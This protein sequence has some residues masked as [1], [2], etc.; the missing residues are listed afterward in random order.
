MQHQEI[1]LG[2]AM[3]TLPAEMTIGADSW[4]TSLIPH[5]LTRLIKGKSRGVA[6]RTLDIG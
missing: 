2:I 1:G 4:V 3:D 5:R 6:P